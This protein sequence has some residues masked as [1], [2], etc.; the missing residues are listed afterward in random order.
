MDPAANAPL[1][2]LVLIVVI[3]AWFGLRALVASLRARKTEAVVHGSFAEYA[4]E[5][6]V[7]AARI[8]NRISAGEASAIGAAMSEI[9][10]GDFASDKVERALASAT[11][12]K[13]ELVAYLKTATHAFSQTQ[14]L[15]LLKALLAVFV[16]DGVF[17]E[18]EH[19]AL[20]DY[21]AA[22]GFDRQSAAEQLR[23]LGRDF[24][25]G[26]IT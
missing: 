4:L 12:S 3:G 16:A 10:G 13:D 2:L 11:L 23:A 15:A 21:T 20:I 18:A 22:V 6:L 9:A 1:A 19:G 14:K 8:D 7:N 24:S 5:V 26:V 25:R 17:D